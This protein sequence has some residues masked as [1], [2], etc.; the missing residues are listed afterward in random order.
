MIDYI[1]QE[2]LSR[3]GNN[4]IPCIKQPVFAMIE[5]VNGDQFFGTNSMVK[6]ESGQC[7]RDL[8]GFKSGQGYHL[9]QE[10]CQQKFHAETAAINEAKKVNANLRD[11]IVYLVGHTY[12]CDNCTKEMKKAGVKKVIFVESNREELM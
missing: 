3:V 1:K 12:C 10:V 2:T 6:I 9:C 7:P 11:S 4:L 5:T 8:Q